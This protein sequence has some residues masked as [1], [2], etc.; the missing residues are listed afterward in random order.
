MDFVSPSLHTLT[1]LMDSMFDEPP[2]VHSAQTSD[3]KEEG[4]NQR[5]LDAAD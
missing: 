2:E 1:L 4:E 3:Q 5:N